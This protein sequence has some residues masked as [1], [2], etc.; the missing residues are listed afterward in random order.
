MNSG[1]LNNTRAKALYYEIKDTKLYTNRVV[2]SFSPSQNFSEI[3]LKVE[4]EEAIVLD[5]VMHFESSILVN[6]SKYAP[7]K[8]ATEMLLDVIN[9]NVITDTDV[10]FERTLVLELW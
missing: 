10:A 2:E 4:H 7:E 8:L 3:E 6:P 9:S 1:Y 5:S